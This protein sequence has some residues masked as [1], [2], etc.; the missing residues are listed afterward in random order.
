MI[1]EFLDLPNF[2][3]PVWYKWKD[4]MIDGVTRFKRLST[5]ITPKRLCGY[6]FQ[7]QTAI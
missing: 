5:D 2:K 3:W 4:E 7:I 1:L 6:F